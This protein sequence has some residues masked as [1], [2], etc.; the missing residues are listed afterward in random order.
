MVPGVRGKTEL[1]FRL[2]DAPPETPKLPRS[3]APGMYLGGLM[4]QS[5]NRAI[6]RKL[7][8]LK[9]KE[10]TAKKFKPYPDKPGCELIETDD[11]MLLVWKPKQAIGDQHAWTIIVKNTNRPIAA[12]KSGNKYHARVDGKHLLAKMMVTRLAAEHNQKQRLTKGAEP[13]EEDLPDGPA[14]GGD[15]SS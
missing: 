7:V 13:H 10:L 14:A 1:E 11:F 6:A 4:S 12:N 8:Q 5:K 9:R 15:G 3:P 2:N